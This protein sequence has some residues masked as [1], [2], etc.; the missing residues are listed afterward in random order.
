MTARNGFVARDAL[1]R[2]VHTHAAPA[3]IVSLVPSET[4]SVC[5]LGASERLVGRTDYCEEP[6]AAAAVPSVGG[7]KR[8]DVE[9]VLELQPDLVLA[10]KE[11]NGERDV[12]ALIERGVT[13]HVSFPTDLRSSADYLRALATLLH[14]DPHESEHVRAADLAVA[15]RGGAVGRRRAFVPIWKDPWMSL[16]GRTY[17]SDVLRAVGLTNVCGDRPRLYPLA[18]DLGDRER[19]TE[20]GGRDTRYPRLSTS[21]IR[22][23]DADLVLLPDEPYRF[24]ESDRDELAELLPRARI[25]LVAGKDLFWYGV[26]MASALERL[27]QAIEG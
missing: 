13:V 19:A 15:A 8:F 20:A 12:T 23:L 17:A 5:V 27:E 10:N 2:E 7:T 26:R 14:L 1:G 11:E 4:E 9:R 18:A 22:A 25:Q 24:G 6:G 21:E 3:R 16:D